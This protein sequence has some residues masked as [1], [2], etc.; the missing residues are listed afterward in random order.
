MIAEI[1][2]AV[3]LPRNLN[4]FSYEIP[5]E[6][7]GQVKVGMVAEIDLR[8]K[9]AAGLIIK[10][11][12]QKSKIKNKETSYQL[13][14]IKKIL[15]PAPLVTP[16]QIDL[17]K[18]IA[19]YYGVSAG[20]VCRSF[21]PQISK[22]FLRMYESY[23]YTNKTPKIKKIKT[24]GTRLCW[25]H[26]LAERNAEYQ[27]IINKNKKQ[28]LILTPQIDFI[29]QL[30]Q[31]LKLDEKKI[32]KIHNGIKLQDFFKHWLK[33]LSGQPAIIIGTK[34]AITLPFTNLQTIIIDEEQ[35]WNHKQSDINPR[36]DARTVAE[37]LAQRHGA[38]LILATPA[39]R[40]ETFYK[41]SH[42][43]DSDVMSEDE[44]SRPTKTKS[45]APQNAG[46]RMTT[47]SLREEKDKGNYSLLSDLLKEKITKTLAAGKKIF[48]LHNRK[49]TANFISCRDCGHV[50]HCPECRTSL[51]YFQ[52]LQKMKCRNCAYTEE[53]PPLC[54]QCGGP[55]LT[56]KSKGVE[57][58][59][60]ELKK[61]FPAT[62]IVAA[63]KKEEKKITLPTEAQ[64]IV[65]T[66]FA[67][68]KFSWP[69]LGLF[70][71]INF[72]QFTN[73]PDFRAPEQ[74]YQLLAGITARCQGELL[75][76]THQPD[77]LILQSWQEKNPTLFYE[78]ELKNRQDFNYPPFGRLLK[79]TFQDKSKARAYYL[80]SQLAQKIKKAND[81]WSVSEPLA[82]WPEKIR[83]RY[84]FHLV[85]KLPLA[86]KQEEIYQLLPPDSLLDFEPE[87][88]T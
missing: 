5:A 7:A 11:K 9:K 88:L 40:V 72:D 26:T 36:S 50:F 62:E 87:K 58:L 52:I 75:I 2:P 22:R 17:I 24:P 57:D 30:S 32:I 21:L 54:P 68:N 25:W 59:A 46:L 86:A 33:I 10:I 73:R 45:F 77:H 64:I 85:V 43:E 84:F 49:G 67:L 41:K 80:S 27:K 15:F 18:K 23:E 8:G 79:I 53:M 66:E 6:L 61:I 48:L 20:I 42:F 35:D 34:L 29:E 19:D 63:F 38:K 4:H 74:T 16:Q 78:T 70:A 39:P 69:A 56:F 71:I 12:N 3:K 76:Q 60:A 47:V 81:H 13:K 31:D 44:E 55:N 83:G 37:W 51:S 28:V 65:G 14:P 1:I 82:A